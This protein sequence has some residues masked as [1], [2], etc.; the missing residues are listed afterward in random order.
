MLAAGLVLDGRYDLLRPPTRVASEQRDR[1]LE[2]RLYLFVTGEGGNRQRLAVLTEERTLG[3]AVRVAFR[4]FHC[5]ESSSARSTARI[6]SRCLR[7]MERTGRLL[8]TT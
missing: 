1:A 5:R 8:R 4:S 3:V 6:S 2:Q 7:S